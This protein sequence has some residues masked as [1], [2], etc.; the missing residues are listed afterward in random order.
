M[1]NITASC[2]MIYGKY[3]VLIC[4]KALT[5]LKAL[6]DLWPNSVNVFKS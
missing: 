2:D 4:C 6:N 3:F 5:D 1:E